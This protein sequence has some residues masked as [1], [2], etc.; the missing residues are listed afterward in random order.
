MLG[1]LAIALVTAGIV[2][3]AQDED[4]QEPTTEARR[5]ADDASAHG[6]DVP[7]HDRRAPDDGRPADEHDRADVLQHVPDD[8]AADDDRH[9]AP[10][11]TQGTTTQGTTTNSSGFT[12][13]PSAPRSGWTVIVASVAKSQG[14]SAAEAKAREAKNRG[15]PDVGILD[16]DQ[17]STI[18]NGYYAVFSGIYDTREGAL[19]NR[20]V[21]RSKGYANAYDKEVVR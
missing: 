14:R 19:A 8:D 11:T 13:W 18:T 10:T 6:H 16:G 1:L 12:Q 20:T 9:D 17:F 7:D 4:G 5:P 3:A 2:L 21:V 15:V